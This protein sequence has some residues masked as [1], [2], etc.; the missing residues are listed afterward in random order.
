VK[1]HKDFRLIATANTL[2]FSEQYNTRQPLDLA[3]LARFD[4][5]TYDLTEAELAIRYGLE[6]I[7][8]VNTENL[9]PREVER[10][11][12]KLKIEGD[13]NELHSL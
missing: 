9:T 8:K 7:L 5:I 12:R 3:T 10:L 13:K 4:I 1:I 6:N 2:T 11:V